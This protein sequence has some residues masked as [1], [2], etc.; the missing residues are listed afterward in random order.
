[1]VILASYNHTSLGLS[2]CGFTTKTETMGK[3]VERSKCVYVFVFIW[4]EHDPTV[5]R[6]YSK[7]EVD[8]VI[9]NVQSYLVVFHGA[10]FQVFEEAV[11]MQTVFIHISIHIALACVLLLKIPKLEKNSTW[12]SDFILMLE[13][14]GHFQ[15]INEHTDSDTLCEIF[16]PVVQVFT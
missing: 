15:T 8:S 11:K 5:A 9:K 13:L 10:S 7:S 1:M 2:M 16:F 12:S 4:K 3:K 14:W 6:W